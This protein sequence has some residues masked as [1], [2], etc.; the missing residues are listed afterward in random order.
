MVLFENKE[1]KQVLEEIV[2]TD[3]FKTDYY[4]QYLY[5]VNY[6]KSYSISRG[7][8]I[9][10]PVN[11]KTLR[12]YVSYDN[13][14]KLLKN[15]VNNNILQ[16]KGNYTIGKFSREY[17]LN[18]NF[19]FSGWYEVQVTDESIK[20]KF[21]KQVESKKADMANGYVKAVEYLSE[22]KLDKESALRDIYSNHKKFTYPEIKSYKD[23]VELFNNKIFSVDDFGNRLHTNLTNF[24]TFLRKYFYNGKGPLKQIDIKNSQPIF[25]GL[26]LKRKG[27]CDPSEVNKYLDI[28]N[29]G[30]FYEFFA[31]KCGYSLDL[32]DKKVRREFKTKVFTEIFFN[33]NKPDLNCTELAFKEHFPSIF[34]YIRETKKTE[35]K[36]LSM[37]LQREESSFIFSLVEDFNFEFYTIHD[38][39]I[40]NENNISY[41]LSMFEKKF[42][43]KYEYIPNLEVE[44]L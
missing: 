7:E 13:A 44:N 33:R 36:T 12:N 17:L 23:S 18:P 39:I 37:Q 20:P 32:T 38:S 5:I 9:P 26:I 1:L 34:N 29:S 43:E 10:T 40:T 11:V 15:L 3:G 2:K 22:L 19:D 25:L 8:E 42:K 30:K 14:H 35:H 6:V 31:D 16:T 41:A 21:Y 27:D 28:C 24:P 4:F